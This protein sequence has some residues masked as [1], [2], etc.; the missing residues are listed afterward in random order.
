[1]DRTHAAQCDRSAR[2]NNM[3]VIRI[4]RPDIQVTKGL[5]GLLE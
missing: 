5:S 3:I 2:R 1:M 4:A